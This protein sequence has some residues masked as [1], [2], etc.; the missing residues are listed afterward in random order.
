MIYSMKPLFTIA[1]ISDIHVDK[2]N[3]RKE[4]FESINGV[5]DLLLIGGDMNNG[6]DEDV[7]N[8]LEL[9]SGVHIPMVIIF[10]NHDCDTGNTKKI[11]DMLLSN[12]FVRVL[13]GEYVEYTINGKTVGIAGAKGY[14]GGFAP[15]R[16]VRRGEDA[17]KAFVDE[18]DREVMKLE[19]ALQQME[20]AAPDF[21]IALTH[22]A[23]FTETIE[24]EPKELYVVLGSSRLGDV[25]TKTSVHLALSGHAHHGSKGIKKAHSIISV[26][27]IGYRVNDETMPL[28]DFF[29]NESVSLRYRESH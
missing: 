1:A 22:W 25:I 27:N 28:F 9:V 20:T 8:F 12:S 5:A 23:A 26:C 11:R 7:K 21:K 6:K 3:L 17:T 15:H 24:G 4:F 18:E 29:S 10:G 14:G 13:D 19:S 16:I 2:Y